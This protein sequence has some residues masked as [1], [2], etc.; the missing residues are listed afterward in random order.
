MPNKI[1]MLAKRP[2]GQ[3]TGWPTSVGQKAVGEKT[4]GEKAGGQKAVGQKAGHPAVH[5]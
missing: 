1:Q 5:G 2:I 4:V 3:N